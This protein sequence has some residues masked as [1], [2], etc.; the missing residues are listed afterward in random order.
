MIT[1]IRQH[2]SSEHFLLQIKIIVSELLFS[3]MEMLQLHQL[4][5]TPISYGLENGSQDAQVFSEFQM[6]ITY[7]STHDKANLIT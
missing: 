5:H 1:F 2:E 6:T 3:T 7:I 4:S